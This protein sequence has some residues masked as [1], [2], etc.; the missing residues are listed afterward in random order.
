MEDSKI[1]ILM[2]SS[3]FNA[4]YYFIQIISSDKHIIIINYHKYYELLLLFSFIII[5]LY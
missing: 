2:M 4:N 5:S 3:N 1:Y